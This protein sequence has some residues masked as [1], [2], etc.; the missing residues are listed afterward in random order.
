MSHKAPSLKSGPDAEFEACV[1]YVDELRALKESDIHAYREAVSAL[2]QIA[3][4]GQPSKTNKAVSPDMA[5]TILLELE[6]FDHLIPPEV[7]EEIR[8]PMP[9]TFMGD[10]QR[11]IPYDD[12]VAKGMLPPE[13]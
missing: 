9:E 10:S 6:E 7:Q 5:D 1:R 4:G 8:K 11:F 12:A 13:D 2:V 3:G